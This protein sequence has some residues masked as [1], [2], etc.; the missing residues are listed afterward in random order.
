MVC[1]NAARSLGDWLSAHGVPAL[2]GVDTRALTQR[3][4]E[5]GAKLG[6]ILFPGE[7]V[8]FANPNARNLVAEVSCRAVRYFGPADGVCILAFDC[9]I[10][11]NIIRYFVH[12]HRVRLV[13]VPFD[14]PLEA[15]PENI[16]YEGIFLSNGPG[17]PSMCTATVQSLRWAIQHRD[18]VPIFGIC[19]G[20][21]L[22]AIACGA[23]TFKMKYGNR[24]MNQPCV[25]LR[26]AKCFITP[27]N[28]GYAVD[29]ASLPPDWKPMFLNA[30]RAAAV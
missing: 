18:P 20:N 24:G 19:L 27:Q 25:D 23:K 30:V 21:Q 3:L 13:V 12:V 4:R 7:S 28:H 22:M 10:K 2:S 8:P 16:V 9:G 26:T 11:F 1:R 5:G 29:N 14:Y 15:N 17:D 6:R